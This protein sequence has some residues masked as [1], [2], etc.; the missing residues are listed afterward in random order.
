MS[1]ISGCD[2]CVWA[3]RCA[4]KMTRRSRHVA[5]TTPTNRVNEVAKTDTDS[6]VGNNR[7]AA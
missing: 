6:P 3:H 7:K 5:L 1:E 4:A 2:D